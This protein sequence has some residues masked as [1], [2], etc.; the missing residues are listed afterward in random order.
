MT[1][2][3]FTLTDTDDR[4]LNKVHP[5]LQRV[6]RRAASKSPFRFKVT[7]GLRSLAQQ[8]LNVKKG[9]SWTL[10][11]RHLTGHAVDICPMVD[12]DKDGKIEVSEMYSWPLYY[13]LAP[14]VKQAAKDLGVTIGWGGDW[15]KN[16]DGPHFELDPKKYPQKSGIAEV[17][18]QPLTSSA[19]TENRAATTTTAIATTGFGT[20]G[21]IAADPVA[22]IANAAINQQAAFSSGDLVQLGVALGVIA[23]TAFLVWRSTRSS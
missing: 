1:T 15:K 7:E 16:K 6:I 11:S 19:V 12:V 18:K 4:I 10:N 23:L 3:G 21:A 9:V 20:G 22:T 2:A 5:D 17:D 13:K 8:K 14:V